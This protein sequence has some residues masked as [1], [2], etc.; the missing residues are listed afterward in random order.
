MAVDTS[1][2]GVTVGPVESEID[3]RWTMAYAAGI[4]DFLPC[5]MDTRRAGGIVAHP[6]FPVC[7]EWPAAGAIRAKPRASLQADEAARG[8]HATPH[9]TAHRA[10][11]PPE[12]FRTTAT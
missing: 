8:V 6:M 12:R 1:W 3:A 4:E 11:R 7:F 10:V 9:L 5:Y 2:V